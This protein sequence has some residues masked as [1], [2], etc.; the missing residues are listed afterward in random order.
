MISIAACQ[1]ESSSNLDEQLVESIKAVSLTGTLDYYTF[2]DSDDYQNLPLQDPANPATEAK[3]KLG[4]LLFFET[5]LAQIPEDELC[6]EAYSCSTCHIPSAGFLPGR[7]QGIADGAW[8]YG[9]NGEYRVVISDYKDELI[10][11]AQGTRPMNPLNAGFSSV[12]LWSG[13]FGAVGPNEGTEDYWTG[14][15]SVNHTGYMGLEAQNIEAFELH[16]LEINEKVLDEYGYRVLYDEAFPE[17]PEEERY[18]PTTSSFA[19]GIFLRSFMS[20]QAPFQEWLKG[21]YD[22]M[23]DSQKEGAKIFFGKANC[24]NCHKEPALNAMA[25][26]ALGTPDMYEIG[27]VN[28]GPDDVRNLGRGM[29]TGQEQDMR[30]FKVPQLYNLKDYSN[31]FHGSS[32]SSLEEVIDFKLK[33]QSENPDVTS[34]M[35]SPLFEAV[36]LTEE[37]KAKLIDFLENALYDANFERYVPESVLS[38]NCFPNNDAFSKTDLGCE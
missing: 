16:R 15:S 23:T 36:S 2:P 18:S 33:A 26:H 7:I 6:Y 31:Y 11:D 3:A 28:T 8:G 29:F 12:T 17:F 9:E 5:G 1:D 21:D 24:T 25:F 10:P 14:L 27:G 37:E 20:N 38:G 13:A 35:V 22:A 19:I 34:D 30:K 32:K 4:N